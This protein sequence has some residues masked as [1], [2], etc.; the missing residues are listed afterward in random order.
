MADG[1]RHTLRYGQ[2]MCDDTSLSCHDIKTMIVEE[3][4]LS[5]IDKIAEACTGDHWRTEPE[6]VH[7][8]R[9]KKAISKNDIT[10]VAQFS[11]SRLNIF[12]KAQA[13]WG[14]PSS[15]VIFLA[16]NTDFKELKAYFERPGKLRLYEPITLTIVKPN[17]S[18]GTHT[19]YPINHL[20]NIGVQTAATDYIYVIDADFVPSSNLYKFAKSSL[21][22][23][24][25]KSNQPLAY[26]VPCVAMEADYKGKY[27]NTVKELQPLMKSGV[28]SITDPRAGHGPTFTTQLFL[29]PP[30]FSGPPAYEVC[31]ESQW[32][33]YYIIRRDWTPYYD[34]RFKNQGGDKQ[35]HALLMNALGFK[36]LVLRDH[37][38][39]HMNHPTLNWTGE[40]LDQDGQKDYTYFEDYSPS[41][42]RIFGK[43]Y[44]WPRG[45]SRPLVQ[46]FKHDL[47]G[48]GTM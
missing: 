20:R 6:I 31:Y 5:V 10:M 8:I 25:E 24:F 4:I 33:P 19:R 18:K 47:Q 44:R 32:E 34:E 27:P 17:F 3:S 45:C 13:S 39:Y 15:V 46:S 43:N 11:I 28:A 14:G 23:I 40:G 30:I 26:V 7:T 2:H 21:I 12:E 38:M 16:T 42:E 48:L 22:P 36:F 37:F 1:R 29:N 9:P 41:M 35:S